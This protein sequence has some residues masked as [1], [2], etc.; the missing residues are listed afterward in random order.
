MNSENNEER[1]ISF[2][3]REWG[4]TTK[5]LIALVVTIA[6]VVSSGIFIF[7][8]VK[9][10]ISANTNDITELKRVNR[11]QDSLLTTKINKEDMKQFNQRGEDNQDL[12]KKIAKKF[13]IKIYDNPQDE[14]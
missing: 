3:K 8:E 5:E 4:L 2:A 6:M 10:T 13:N 12:L 9:G 14:Q 11:V 7:T 1:A